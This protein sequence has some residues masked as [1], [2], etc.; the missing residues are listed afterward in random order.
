MTAPA[1]ADGLG[2]ASNEGTDGNEGSEG[3][4]LGISGRL[5]AETSMLTRAN[6]LL[7]MTGKR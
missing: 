2:I 5:G 1:M 7:G 6:G 3:I 4:K